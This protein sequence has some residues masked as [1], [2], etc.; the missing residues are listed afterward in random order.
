MMLG[1]VRRRAHGASMP[2]LTNQHRLTTG[3]RPSMG[4][5]RGG[6]PTSLLEILVKPPL[7][8]SAGPAEPGLYL[9]EVAADSVDVR[10]QTAAVRTVDESSVNVVP[11]L[12]R[13]AFHAPVQLYPCAVVPE[14]PRV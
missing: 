9:R 12:V 5:N 10:V 14:R 1:S 6:Q 8:R 2:T 4:G 13:G 7:V 3:N 11:L